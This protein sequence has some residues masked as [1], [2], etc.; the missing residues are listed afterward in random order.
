M[1]QTGSPF[2]FVA[3]TI[4]PGVDTIAFSLAVL[5]LAN[6]TVTV[7]A[8]PH[9]V[10]RL[11]A[12]DPLAIVDFAI[13]PGVGSLPVGFPQL[14]LALVGVAVAE[15][16]KASAVAF[17]SLPLSFEDAPCVVDDD[18]L[19]VA[20]PLVIDLPSVDRIFVLLDIKV[21]RL[22][23]EVLVVELL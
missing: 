6:I 12:V 8:F 7:D 19:A 10:A 1:T 5:P 17:I 22:L 13:A 16:L 18:A 9:S 21:G 20:L 15:Q 14:V 23:A 2:S 4:E 11:L 3:I